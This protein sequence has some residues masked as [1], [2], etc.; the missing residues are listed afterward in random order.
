MSLINDSSYVQYYSGYRGFNGEVFAQHHPTGSP[1]GELPLSSCN[2]PPQA[3]RIEPVN[4]PPTLLHANAVL[5]AG[6]SAVVLGFALLLVS[7]RWRE[8]HGTS[9]AIG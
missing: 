3:E 4:L 9:I 8:R 7:R 6:V 2:H 5:L 1:D